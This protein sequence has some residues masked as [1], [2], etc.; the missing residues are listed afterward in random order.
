MRVVASIA[1]FLVGCSAQAID[2]YPLPAMPPHAGT[3][4]PVEVGHAAPTT[5][6]FLTP[7][8]GDEI[9]LLGAEPIGVADGATVRFYVSPPVTKADGSHVIGEELDE[10]AGASFTNAT[11]TDSADNTFGIVAEITPMRPG[12]YELNNVRLRYRL[13][14][15][16]EEVREGIDVVFAVCAGIDKSTPCEASLEPQPDG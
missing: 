11:G 7:R 13:N 12:R 8:P 3:A 16:P 4:L 1:V 2:P 5:V 6:L 14:G 9:E 10:L 15:G